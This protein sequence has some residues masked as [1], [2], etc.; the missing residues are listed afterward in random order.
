MCAAVDRAA[1]PLHGG[2][3]AWHEM[4]IHNIDMNAV[5][6]GPLRSYA[7]IRARYADTSSFDVTCPRVI[8]S[9]SSVMPFSI[10]S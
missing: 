1:Q 8:A 7:A 4:P 10:T 6:A 3:D 9:C 5:S 2:A